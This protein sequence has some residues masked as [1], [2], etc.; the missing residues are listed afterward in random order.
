M[1]PGRVGS[2]HAKSILIVT[3]P[4]S[5][6]TSIQLLSMGLASQKCLEGHGLIVLGVLS[7]AMTLSFSNSIYIYSW[8]YHD[9]N[10]SSGTSIWPVGSGTFPKTG[11]RKSSRGHSS[12]ETG[13]PDNNFS[14]RRSTHHKNIFSLSQ[15]FWVLYSS[16]TLFT[17]VLVTHNA[18]VC[19]SVS[20]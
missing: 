19:I 3:V 14:R 1:P 16:V 11:S 7:L 15:L 12:G 6:S 20:G 4:A 10:I 17:S 8:R 5:S 2:W 13:R 18:Q 9:R